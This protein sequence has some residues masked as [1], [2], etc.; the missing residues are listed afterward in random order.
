MKK[1]K[2]RVHIPAANGRKSTFWTFRSNLLLKIKNI[3]HINQ[4]ARKSWKKLKIGF[5]YLRQTAEKALFGRS[6]VIFCQKLEISA[7]SIKFPKK[8]AKCKV[9][10]R[11]EQEFI[12]VRT[13]ANILL[14]ILSHS[15]YIQNMYTKHRTH[16]H[17]EHAPINSDNA[18]KF[19]SNNS[20]KLWLNAH[21]I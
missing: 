8:Q 14:F 3:C 5:I 21:G 10:L 2:Y 11:Y 12:L 18:L 6:G 19:L 17:T 9:I 20:F 7:I 4:I 13:T 1:A 16:V 15:N